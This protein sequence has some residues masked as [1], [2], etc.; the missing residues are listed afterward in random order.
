MKYSSKKSSR[1][2]S[3]V[4]V[5]M[6]VM[7]LIMV[8][9]LTIAVTLPTAFVFAEE[10]REIDGLP[11]MGVIKEGVT[12]ATKLEQEKNQIIEEQED[13]IGSLKKRLRHSVRELEDIQGSISEF[14]FD[15]VEQN[16]RIDSID[17]QI[18]NVEKQIEATEGKIANI[19]KQITIK[20]LEI[21]EFFEELEIKELQMQEQSEVF[22]AYLNFLY[23]QDTTFYDNRSR[24][25]NLFK[26]LLDDNAFSENISEIKFLKLFEAQAVLIF[27]QLKELESTLQLQK[28]TLE[29][30]RKS[31]AL[32]RRGVQDEKTNL[33]ALKIGKK[34]LLIQTQG[35]K[36]VYERLAAKDREAEEQ[37]ASEISMITLNIH[38]FDSALKKIKEAGSP[39]EIEEAIRIRDDMLE[40]KRQEFPLNYGEDL[41]LL[42][43]PISPYRGL[44]AYFDDASYVARFGV[45]H[46][47]IDIR[48]PQ[49]S[50]IFAPADG[51]VYSTHGKG[52]DDMDYHYI[53][54]THRNGIQ[55]VYGHLTRI[56]VSEGQFARKGDLIA[57]TGG[58]PGTTGSGLRT[59]GPHLHFEVHQFGKRVDPLD[60]LPLSALPLK[61]IPQDKIKLLYEEQLKD[62]Y[63]GKEVEKYE[64]DKKSEGQKEANEGYENE[65]LDEEV[66][67]GEKIMEGEEGEEVAGEKD[68]LLENAE[69]LL[70]DTAFRLHEEYENKRREYKEI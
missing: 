63:D 13:L 34:R 43:W 33:E 68:A 28:D 54:L 70:D 22:S 64:W 1:W 25:F 45:P 10:S 66:E 16:E 3:I 37:I 15:I 4:V 11:E 7:V 60:F 19:T 18:E 20:E 51:I 29:I 52:I 2:T 12:E 49:N 46:R 31:L 67:G 61:S 32:L 42:E 9:A 39:D 30:N 58:I 69:D 65:T 17:K 59:T 57:L 41:A 62:K 38:A 47:A 8:V 56:I 40:L 14:H 24:E 35:K 48:A 36:M 5:L 23:F 27:E 55:T 44:S 26:L 50:P 6:M 53:I 21:G